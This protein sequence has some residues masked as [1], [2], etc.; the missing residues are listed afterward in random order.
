MRRRLGQLWRW[1][2]NEVAFRQEQRQEARE[3]PY[4][5]RP[6]RSELEDQLESMQ[7]E[8]QEV[9]LRFSA[10]AQQLAA[11]TERLEVTQ[12]ALKAALAKVVE[13]KAQGE[14]ALAAQSKFLETELAR[15][16]PAPG[17]SH[18]PCPNCRATG[19]MGVPAGVT[20]T[21]S[22]PYTCSA[23]WG[24]GQRRLAFAAEVITMGCT[25]RQG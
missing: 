10:T 7:T 16:R 11:Q 4:S 9:E 13:A 1:L 24:S 18:A 25:G 6:T 21:P 22:G 19:F 20:P 12:V 3:S 8:L 14:A 15:W 23:C 5:G 2:D 17:A